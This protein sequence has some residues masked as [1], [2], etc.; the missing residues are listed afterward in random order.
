MAAVLEEACTVPCRETDAEAWWPDRKQLDG[1]GA[2]MAVAACWAC[3][4]KDACLALAVAAGEREGIWEATLPDEWRHM[5]RIA[6]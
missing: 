5:L 2:R 4:A 1:T 3:P 6:A